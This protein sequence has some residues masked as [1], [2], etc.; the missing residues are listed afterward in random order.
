MR[1][2][3]NAISGFSPPQGLPGSA[4]GARAKTVG[5]PETPLKPPSQKRG[6]PKGVLEGPVGSLDMKNTEIES[7]SE[8]S[9]S[10]QNNFSTALLDKSLHQSMQNATEDVKIR[11][12]PI[13][14][15]HQRLRN[16]YVVM[17]DTPTLGPK[18]P[19]GQV[20]GEYPP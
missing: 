3:C 14:V 1:G 10:L 16:P 13:E 9:Q 2:S 11:G 8:F 6:S 7:N 15:T 5:A 12:R 17:C 20:S 4:E 18:S 19:L